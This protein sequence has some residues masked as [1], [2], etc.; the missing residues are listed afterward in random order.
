MTALSDALPLSQA[1]QQLLPKN[2]AG[3]PPHLST[4]LRWIYRGVIVANG[5]RVFLRAA[6]VGG[7]TYIWPADVERFVTALS[8]GMPSTDGTADAET[9]CGSRE[10]GRS[11]EAIRT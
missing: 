9:N 1:L 8:A 10:A 5:Q 6:K 11:L 2:R 3:K 4:A 7:A